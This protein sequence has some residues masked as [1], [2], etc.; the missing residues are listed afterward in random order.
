VGDGDE[1]LPVSV[2]SLWLW[3]SCERNNKTI[4]LK[5]LRIDENVYDLICF[6]DFLFEFFFNL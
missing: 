3:N 5:R 4:K 6:Q 1:A 2:L